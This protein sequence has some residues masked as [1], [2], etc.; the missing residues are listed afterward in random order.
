MARKID[1][2]KPLNADDE[3]YVRERPWLARDAELEGHTVSYESGPVNDDSIVPP[4]ANNQPSNTTATEDE[5]S[6]DEVDYNSFNK[7]DLQ[8]EVDARN[9]DRDEDDKIV[10]A[11]K[12]TKADLVA[13][14]EADD[15]AI[16]AGVDEE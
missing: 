11:G 6:E 9:E 1:F 3:Q 14:L 4:E 13:A 8:V 5:E 10:V 2:T 7:A 16:D 12:G 15:A